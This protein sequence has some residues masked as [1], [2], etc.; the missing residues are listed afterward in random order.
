MLDLLGYWISGV[1]DLAIISIRATCSAHGLITSQ[2]APRQS[3][4]P[5]MMLGV[6]STSKRIFFVVANP[7][8]PDVALST[9]ALLWRW[10]LRS[11]AGSS[12]KAARF[13]SA[14]ASLAL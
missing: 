3:C 4:L 2:I 12:C 14:C 5:A 7:P 13:Y 9:F 11:A 1:L 10:V 6:H 8:A